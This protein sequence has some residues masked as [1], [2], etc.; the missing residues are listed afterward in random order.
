MGATNSGCAQIGGAVF[1]VSLGSFAS[2]LVGGVTHNRGTLEQQQGAL[3][4]EQG[5]N[6]G[7]RHG[8]DDNNNCKPN[9]LSVMSYSRWSAALFP[10][11]LDYSRNQLPDLDE[12]NGPS[13]AAGLGGGASP[14]LPANEQTAFGYVGSKNVNNYKVVPLPAASIDWNQKSG[15]TASNVNRI[16]AIGCDGIPNP[17]VLHGFNDWANFHFNLRASLEFAGG[18]DTEQEEVTSED[19]QL[20]F[21]SLD[22]DSKP[23][24]KR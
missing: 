22:S 10:R 23:S 7:F 14:P 18:G 4:H 20:A 3:M 19:E 15:Q 13:E 1:V 17:T 11:R 24:R 6:H 9:Y 5:H 12:N 21:W 8:G 16:D 2:T